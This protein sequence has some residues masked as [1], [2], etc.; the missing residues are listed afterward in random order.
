MISFPLG[1]YKTRAAAE[2]A[3]KLWSDIYP[4]ESF[5]IVLVGSVRCV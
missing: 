3:A 5:D 1:L 4:D 2:E